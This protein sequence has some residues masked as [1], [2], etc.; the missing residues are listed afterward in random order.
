MKD[1]PHIG[2]MFASFLVEQRAA[3]VL[4]CEALFHRIAH[5]YIIAPIR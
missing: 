1:E 3:E 2:F 4:S 5:Q